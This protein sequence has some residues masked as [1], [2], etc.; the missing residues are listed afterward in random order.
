MPPLL[1]ACDNQDQNGI[2]TSN[3]DAAVSSAARRSM[4]LLLQQGSGILSSSISNN[5]ANAAML[6]SLPEYQDTNAILQGITIDVADES[7]YE[8]TIQF[9]LNSFDGMKV[10]RERQQQQQGGVRDTV[11][12]I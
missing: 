10:L 2:A 12:F 3:D 4:I 11:S 1:A 9:F 6:G 8:E 7:Q 5:A